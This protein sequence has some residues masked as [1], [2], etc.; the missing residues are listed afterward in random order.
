MER[1]SHIAYDPNRVLYTV[2][3]D[4][5]A[6]QVVVNSVHDTRVGT[7]R[8]LF[9]ELYPACLRYMLDPD[10]FTLFRAKF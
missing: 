2:P 8:T 1:S 7:F 4:F 10:M 9:L 5:I 6:C 3:M